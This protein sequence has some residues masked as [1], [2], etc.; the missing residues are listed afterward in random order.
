ME[1]PV[2]AAK[3][4]EKEKD[5]E[6]EKE[7][8]KLTNKYLLAW[9]QD[10]Q[11]D[12]REYYFSKANYMKWI[13]RQCRED[14]NHYDTPCTAA[15]KDELK[16][17]ELGVRRCQ[18]SEADGCTEMPDSI[19]NYYS[20]RTGR[21]KQKRW[22]E[23]EVHA[24][25]D[26]YTTAAIVEFAK[27]IKKYDHVGQQHKTRKFGRLS[28]TKSRQRK[29]RLDMYHSSTVTNA[30]MFICQQMRE[31]PACADA[32]RRELVGH[33]AF[34]TKVAMHRAPYY[35][36]EKKHMSEKRKKQIL[37]PELALYVFEVLRE[38]KKPSGWIF[39]RHKT[40]YPHNGTIDQAIYDIIASSE[41]GCRDADSSSSAFSSSS[42]SSPSSSSSSSDFTTTAASPSMLNLTE[43]DFQLQT[44]WSSTLWKLAVF[45]VDISKKAVMMVWQ[46]MCAVARFIYNH[47]GKIFMVII[48]LAGIFYL[49]NFLLSCG[50]AMKVFDEFHDS[51]N[52]VN[53]A[54]SVWTIVKIFVGYIKIPKGDGPGTPAWLQ[55]RTMI[56]QFYRYFREIICLLLP[57][58][59]NPTV[60]VVW[61][62]SACTA[63]LECYDTNQNCFDLHCFLFGKERSP[64]EVSKQ[65]FENWK[66]AVPLPPKEAK[67]AKK[68]ANAILSDQ[69][70]KGLQLSKEDEKQVMVNFAQLG[71]LI[72]NNMAPPPDFLAASQKMLPVAVAVPVSAAAPAIPVLEVMQR[73]GVL[74]EVKGEELP[75][76]V[77]IKKKIEEYKYKIPKF[78]FKYGVPELMKNMVQA[79]GFRLEA[80]GWQ[81]TLIKHAY[82]LLQLMMNWKKTLLLQG[83]KMVVGSSQ[84]P[85]VIQGLEFTGPIL[86]NVVARLLP[87][88]GAFATSVQMMG[89]Y[90]VNVAESFLKIQENSPVA[91]YQ[92]FEG[93]VFQDIFK[94]DKK[95]RFLGE[96]SEIRYEDTDLT[97]SQRFHEVFGDNKLIVF[98][99]EFLRNPVGKVGEFF[100]FL[101][102]MFA[103]LSSFFPRWLSGD[104]TAGDIPNP[105]GI[106]GLALDAVNWIKSLF[107]KLSV[108]FSGLS[109]GFNNAFLSGI[110]S[111]IPTTGYEKFVCF[112]GMNIVAF[113]SGVF[114]RI[115]KTPLDKLPSS[116][117]E[118]QKKQQSKKVK[119][120]KSTSNQIKRKTSKLRRAFNL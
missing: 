86:T 102:N 83:A 88:L 45:M 34:L 76:P 53:N 85:F 30:F 1:E 74:M 75:Q 49:L 81:G 58:L 64:E 57:T 27:A 22:T 91:L 106:V 107:F 23:T 3:E 70:A 72:E 96:N 66:N 28:S 56:R 63:F 11:S 94:C 108:S 60:A 87:G 112:A 110:L 95:M 4:K 18:F 39:G 17:G 38:K 69:K 14:Q 44:P 113:F 24:I 13:G 47:Y 118:S 26:M 9:F 78:A 37:L 115:Y 15:G 93:V 65:I 2:A 119:N 101:S 20:H 21:V 42:S 117:P 103:Y 116:K 77:D 84:N 51:K 46:V 82:T 32:I 71:K 7:K 52:I 48:L 8:K 33:D 16:C 40:L 90:A 10:S 59:F 19:C 41:K 36:R 61:F 25:E 98:L 80:C 89:P 55:F 105:G 99:A 120:N 67:E 6:K 104:L 73:G 35:E 50:P 43:E 111:G 97:S 54:D 31:R 79:K 109:D 5:K 12:F 100:P 114:L 92:Y 62:G 29:I 68:T